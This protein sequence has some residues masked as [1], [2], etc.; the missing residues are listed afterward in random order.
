MIPGILLVACIIFERTG[1]CVQTEPT[2][3]EIRDRIPGDLLP[4]REP[5]HR[6]QGRDPCRLD[7][8]QHYQ[9]SSPVQLV[10]AQLPWPRRAC[11]A[12]FRNSGG[13]SGEGIGILVSP[14]APFLLRNCERARGLNL[15]RTPGQIFSFILESGLGLSKP[16]R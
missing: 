10:D 1:N 13:F 8:L 15:L 9:R 6:L 16:Q 3:A 5:E 12:L 7:G 2:L 14:G 11:N 4:P